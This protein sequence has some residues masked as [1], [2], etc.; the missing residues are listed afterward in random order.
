M[1]HSQAKMVQQKNIALL[2]LF[3]TTEIADTGANVSLP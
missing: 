3:L 1:N 2:D